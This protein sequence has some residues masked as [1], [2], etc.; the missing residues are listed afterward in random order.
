MAKSISSSERMSA[1]MARSSAGRELTVFLPFANGAIVGQ[2]GS[3]AP[4]A[5]RPVIRRLWLV[6]HRPI[7]DAHGR[8]RPVHTGVGLI[9]R[10]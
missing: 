4:L 8:R 6:E 7:L 5:G 10:R 3:R 9:S 1:A 2:A